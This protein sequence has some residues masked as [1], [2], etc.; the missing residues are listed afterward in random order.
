MLQDDSN[1]A[2]RESLKVMIELYNKNIWNDGK[3]VNAISTG[4]YSSDTKIIGIVL[5]F[6]LSP[7][8]MEDEDMVERANKMKFAAERKF[9]HNYAGKKKS[10]KRKLETA[11]AKVDKI[12]RKAVDEKYDEKRNYNYAAINLINDP[13]HYVEKVFGVLKKTNHG[14]DMKVRIM[15]FVARLIS[16]HQLMLESFYSF[17]QKYCQPH[18]QYVT[19]LLAIFAT[20]CHMMVSPDV[21]EGPLRAIANNFVSDRRANEVIALGLNSIREICLRCPL[22]MNET[23]LHDLIQ[24][25]KSKDKSVMMAARSLLGVYRVLNPSLLPK[26]ERGKFA[27]IT[28]EPLAYGQ[29]EVTR[30]IPGTEYLNDESKSESSEWEEV[31]EGEF[32]DQT[33][34]ESGD[35]ETSGQS[36]LSIQSEPNIK[37]RLEG[38]E[39]LTDDQWEKLHDIQKDMMEKNPNQ[40]G[41]KRRLAEV[42]NFDMD[43]ELEPEDLLGVQKRK[44]ITKEE[45]IM[46]AKEG[47]HTKDIKPERKKGEHLSKTHDESKK[48]KPYAMIKHKKTRTA[49]RLSSKQR[50]AKRGKKRVHK[51]RKWH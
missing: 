24:Y 28:V 49:N 41:I 14:F 40:F 26:K 21:L 35:D 46:S 17:M 12:R 31:I 11:L 32:V 18:Q 51:H 50:Q 48:N 7:P 9:G 3:T 15:A 23:L 25:K 20:A 8:G 19:Q 30:F 39:L 36:E 2:P 6:F 47:V 37:K 22:A 1:I 45:K 43:A 10:R 42:Y 44:K 5:N 16:T 4:L 33:D 27:D 38:N 29:Q 34:S 13:Q